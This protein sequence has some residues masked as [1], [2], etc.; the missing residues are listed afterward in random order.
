MN[1]VA[2][3][4]SGFKDPA[5][6]YVATVNPLRIVVRN[7]GP[8]LVFLAFSPSDLVEASAGLAGQFQLPSDR[9]EVFV[10]APKQGIYAVS[11]G[12]DGVVSISVSEAF[13]E[14]L[15]RA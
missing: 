2:V 14:A 9:S 7:V 13:P 4:I 6:L 1:T 8:A 10:L 12:G 5:T 15:V 3:P 11:L